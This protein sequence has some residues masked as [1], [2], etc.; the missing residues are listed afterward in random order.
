MFT[1]ELSTVAGLLSIWRLVYLE[2][3]IGDFQKDKIH[4]CSLNDSKVI[5]GQ[6]QFCDFD[7]KS[8]KESRFTS[9]SSVFGRPGFDS[10]HAQSLRLWSFGAIQATCTYFTFLEINIFWD[11]RQPRTHCG[12][13][14]LKTMPN[15]ENFRIQI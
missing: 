9:R 13:F 1:K 6:K 4:V 10:R 12:R 7:G 2:I 3:M 15:Y 11:G 5:S 14:W 8:S